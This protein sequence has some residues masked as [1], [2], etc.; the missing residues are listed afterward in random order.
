MSDGEVLQ[1]AMALAAPGAADPW[2]GEVEFPMRSRLYPLGFAVDISTNSPEV[3]ACA[4]ESW[5][6]FREAFREPPLRLR[7]G[8]ATGGSGHCP[9]APVFRSQC[10]LLAAVADAGNFMVS[11]LR[12]GFA[13]GW[14]T[15]AAVR[16]DAYLRYH[17]L[18]GTVLCLLESLYT[19]PLH[20]AC[21]ES[22]GTGFLL[23]GDSGAG[24][25]SLAFA[26]ARRGWTFISDDA[27]CIVRRRNGRTVIGNPGRMRFRAS[28]A[29]LFP[30]LQGLTPTPRPSGKIAIEV[31]TASHPE[32]ATANECFIDYIIFLNRREPGPSALMP[33]PKQ[34][35]LKWFEEALILGNA[36]TRE[37]QSASLHTL[38]AAEVLELRYRDLS[39]AVDQLNALV[40]Q[41]G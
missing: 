5:G 4:R 9:P 8:V 27:T 14:L 19:T 10:N 23:C 20:G 32:I 6:R 18:E 40:Q 41:R 25:S 24:K 21:V 26:C 16:N 30:E 35:A 7:I 13:F 11:D 2:L 31:T 29:K 38:L 17:F 36:E 1:G 39:W 3:L 34:S 22:G 33:Y 12:G 15:P 28:A 37:A